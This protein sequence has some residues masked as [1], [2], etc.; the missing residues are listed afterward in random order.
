MT[1][2]IRPAIAA[3]VAALHEL[4]ALTFPLACPPSTTEASKAAFI[5]EH[6]SVEAFGRYLRDARRDIT[7][8]EDAGALVG[9]A[10]LV[11]GEPADP[12]VAQAVR[13]RPTAELSKLYVHPSHHGGGVAS[14]LVAAAVEA[15]S[16]RKAVSVWLGVNQHNARA[17]R[18][19][20]KSGFET[21]GSKRFLVGDT[22]EDDWVRERPL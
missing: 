12:D 11:H 9:Y 8:A 19:Y 17:N 21:V 18:F 16:R 10:M 20:A 13:A 4:A 22:W 3:E 6:L 15:A 2:R 1:A 14:A 5:A 7:V